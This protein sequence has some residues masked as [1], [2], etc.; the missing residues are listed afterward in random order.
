MKHLRVIGC[1]AQTNVPDAKRK[2]LDDK[3]IKC[4]F[5]GTSEE[6]KVYRLYD[7]SSK[8]VIISREVVFSEGENWDWSGDEDSKGKRKAEEED[9]AIESETVT[10]KDTDE[11]EHSEITEGETGVSW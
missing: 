1:I 9:I 5:L 2:K 10:G 7:S 8:R 3:S 6:S 11:G 4:V